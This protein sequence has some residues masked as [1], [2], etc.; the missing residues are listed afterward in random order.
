[1]INRRLT[2][3]EVA[4]AVTVGL[5]VLDQVVIGPVVARWQEQSARL[6][7]LRKEVQEGR[8]LLARE[9]NI[10]ER[11]AEMQLRD[12]PG[13]GAEAENEVFKAVARWGRAGRITFTGLNPQWR[14]Y[15]DGYATLECRA[16]ATGDQAGIAR[17]LEELETDPLAVRLESFELSA[18]DD[19][20]R[21]L[22]LAARFTALR[23]ESNSATTP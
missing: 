15:D 19:Q 7:V 1:M 14:T 5:L 8:A 17:F 12:L 16:S 23:I 3:L 21:R 11:W 9:A 20:G 2:W 13:D 18:I 10:R 4:T 22:N 6:V